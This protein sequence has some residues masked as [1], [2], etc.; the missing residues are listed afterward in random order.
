LPN[1][2]VTESNE[3]EARWFL[4]T[5]AVLRNPPGAPRVPTLIEL[6]VPP[7]GS[8]PRH[9]HDAMD[10]NFLLLQGEVLVSCGGRSF[11]ARPGA[12]VTLPAGVEHTFRVTGPEAAMML[13]VHARDDFWDFIEAAGTPAP[14]RAV[15]PAGAADLDREALTRTAAAH[16]VRI[17]GPPLDDAE[18]R[19][20]ATA[21]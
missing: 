11:T 14:Q 4:G 21:T 9:V 19:R 8:P 7:G 1:A 10:D 15:P 5:L 2:L 20:L 13:L 6:T 12:Y 3:G 17:V 18:A 16:D